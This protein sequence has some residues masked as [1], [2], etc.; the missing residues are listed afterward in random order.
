VQE[1]PPAERMRIEREVTQ[2][3]EDA[4]EV[5]RH[6]SQ[7]LAAL[8]R[9]TGLVEAPAENEA[10]ILRFEV[11]PIVATRVAVMVADTYGRVRTFTLNLDRVVSDA[12]AGR[13]N[14][15]LNETLRRVPLSRLGETVRARAEAAT[16]E[17]RH[18][19]EL[20]LAVLNGL[21]VQRESQVF[22]EGA[23]QLFEQP[24]FRD[25]SRAHGVFSLLEE[26]K[27]LAELLRT[28]MPQEAS[29]RFTVVIGSEAGD[30]ALGEVSVVVAPYRVGDKTVGALGILGPR[31]MPYSRLAA[32]VDYTADL[33][34]RHLTRLA[35]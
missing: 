22:L 18:V 6:V 11:V 24:E 35:G 28:R 34:G 15:F 1:L 27:R 30:E 33:L 10:E 14:Q 26:R 21:P 9:Q 17:E 5:M 13:L 31:R 29:P 8:S 20:A 23:S 32:L 7:L 16:D 12:E 25:I 4:E 2:S 19:A 3:S